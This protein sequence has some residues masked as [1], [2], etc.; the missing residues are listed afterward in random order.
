[1]TSLAHRHPPVPWARAHR[2]AAAAAAAGGHYAG[3][4]ALVVVLVVLL[5]LAVLAVTGIDTGGRLPHP[6]P[7]PAPTGVSVR[8]G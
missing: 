6:Q 5:A 8:G 4:L 3:A 7:L 2:S 1:M